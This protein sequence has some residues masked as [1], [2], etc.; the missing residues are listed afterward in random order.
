VPA[1]ILLISEARIPTVRLL[2]Q[3]LLHVTT[4]TGDVFRSRT[5]KELS[6]RDLTASTVPI[7]VRVDGTPA[8]RLM[9]LMRKFEVDYWYY[10]DDNFWELS[11]ETALGRYYADKHVRKHLEELLGGAHRVLVSTPALRDY[12]H[13][14]GD[15]VAQLDSFFNFSLVPHLPESPGIRPFVRGGFASSADRGVD[16]LPVV[17]ELFAALDAHPELEFELIGPDYD[18]IPE[19]DRI[20]RFPILENYESYVRFQLERQW[21]FAIAPLSGVRSNQYKTDNK[22]REYAAF[23]IPGIY[24]ESLPYESV[25]DGETGLIVADTGRTWREAIE[26]YVGGPELRAAVRTAAREDV[27][28][29]RSID[30]VSSAWVRELADAPQIGPQAARLRRSVAAQLSVVLFGTAVSSLIHEGPITM[31]RRTVEY[32]GRRRPAR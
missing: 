18:A 16:L 20:R 6:R 26:S 24:Q 31:S 19:H 15:R 28:Q 1:D 14:F 2:E 8:H 27:E 4:Q 29:R 12:L 5:L 7:F 13:R 3:I 17:P 32:F 10:L 23:G 30:V 21:D 22:Y 25:R 11:Q 9:K